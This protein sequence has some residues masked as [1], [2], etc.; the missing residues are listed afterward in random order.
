MFL[1]GA[2]CRPSSASFVSPVLHPPTGKT[3]I[4]SDWNQTYTLVIHKTVWITPWITTLLDVRRFLITPQSENSTN[5]YPSKPRSM[6]GP[7]PELCALQTVEY[8]EILSVVHRIARCLL[9]TI[10]YVYDLMTVNLRGAV[11]RIDSKK[12]TK[13]NLPRSRFLFSR[14]GHTARAKA[15]PSL[16]PLQALLT[17]RFVQRTLAIENTA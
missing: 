7:T 2:C 10:T 5:C 16:P 14:G 12:M 3:D 11:S 6:Q 4:L 17:H 9:T 13:K 15:D 1:R 8:V